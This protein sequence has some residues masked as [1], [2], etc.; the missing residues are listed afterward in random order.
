[1]HDAARRRPPPPRPPTQQQHTLSQRGARLHCKRQI[2]IVNN[3]FIV[4]THISNIYMQKKRT[5]KYFFN[6]QFDFFLMFMTRNV[7][8]DFMTRA[9]HADIDIE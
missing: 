3:Y 6:I 2:I 4:I 8:R 5:Y 1:M 9:L 7:S